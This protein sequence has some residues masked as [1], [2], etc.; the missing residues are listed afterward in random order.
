MRTVLVVIAALLVTLTSCSG[1][2]DCD[3]RTDQ[4]LATAYQRA[5]GRPL[6]K[7]GACVRRSETFPGLVRIGIFAMDRG[8][9]PQGVLVG[10]A[11]SPP[12]FDAAAM[13]KAGWQTANA[14]RRQQLALAWLREIEDTGFQD[15][16]DLPGGKHLTAVAV[17]PTHDGLVIEGWVEEPAGMTPEANYDKLRVTFAADGTHAPIAQLDHL[18]VPMH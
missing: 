11:V 15:A 3:V 17:T 2:A 12:G 13:K 14:A 1:H 6:P 8:C 7:D 4:G 5:T 18:T 9:I 16:T 10:C